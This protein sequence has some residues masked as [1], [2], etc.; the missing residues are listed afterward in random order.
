MAATKN[1]GLESENGPFQ[2][3]LFQA[4]NR[5]FLLGK[6][7]SALPATLSWFISSAVYLFKFPSDRSVSTP[8]GFVLEVQAPPLHYQD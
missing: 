2:A 4:A 6:S 5:I 7:S 8:Q 1:K 3:S